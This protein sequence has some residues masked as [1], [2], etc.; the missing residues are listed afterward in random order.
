MTTPSICPDINLNKPEALPYTFNTRSNQK[1]EQLVHVRTLNFWFAL[2][3][4]ETEFDRK[5]EVE[6]LLRRPR[7]AIKSEDSN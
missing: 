6:A 5:T 3:A 4:F 1:L 7:V 2:V